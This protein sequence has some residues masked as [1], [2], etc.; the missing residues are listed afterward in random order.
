ME[1]A[2]TRTRHMKLAW[3]SWIR[4][5]LYILRYTAMSDNTL[6]LS[7]SNYL[8]HSDWANK[9]LHRFFIS[10]VRAACP[11]HLTFEKYIL[12]IILLPGIRCGGLLQCQPP[13]RCVPKFPTPPPPFACKLCNVFLKFVTR[14]QFPI[15]LKCLHFVCD[16][17]HI[18]SWIS[19]V[20]QRR[21]CHSFVNEGLN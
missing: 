9:I 3:V 14:F 8:F 13:L 16:L 11:A 21:S 15:F 2:F 17:I 5:H 19:L 7:L 18:Y 12:I 4:L 6:C 10:F 20:H 1:T